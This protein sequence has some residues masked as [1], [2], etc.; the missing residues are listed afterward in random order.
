M[1]KG[2]LLVIP[3]ELSSHSFVWE[4][5]AAYVTQPGPPS[6]TSMPPEA[7]CPIEAKVNYQSGQLLYHVGGT[8]SSGPALSMKAVAKLPLS[9]FFHRF[10]SDTSCRLQLCESSKLHVK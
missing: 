2:R 8:S 5:R 6:E 9:I 7:R 4:D 10:K 3:A 1:V